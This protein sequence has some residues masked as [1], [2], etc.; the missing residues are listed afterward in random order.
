MLVQVV[1]L[2]F[3][4]AA[5]AFALLGVRAGRI[6]ADFLPEGDG[7]A[8]LVGKHR[9]EAAAF[10]GALVIDCCQQGEALIEVTDALQ[11]ITSVRLR[12]GVLWEDEQVVAAFQRVGGKTEGLPQLRGLFAIDGDG[13]KLMHAPNAEPTQQKRGGG[14]QALG[15]MLGGAECVF[16][17]IIGKLLRGAH[18]VA[19][20]PGTNGLGDVQHGGQR[21]VDRGMVAQEY[22]RI[23]RVLVDVFGA[24][25]LM[26]AE[27]TEQEF[28]D[29]GAKGTL[30]FFDKDAFHLTG[31]GIVDFSRG[32]QSQQTR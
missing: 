12:R 6:V 20:D 19:D 7:L 13:I 30:A 32:T 18:D 16:E 1:H 24:R 10:A 8:F 9:Q 2:L 31:E 25:K 23:I 14:L 5:D 28:E 17:E 26:T 21:T 29:V 3:R 22:Q 11:N 4:F 27:G 15:I